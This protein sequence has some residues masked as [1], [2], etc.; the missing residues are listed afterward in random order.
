MRN[1]R[2]CANLQWRGKWKSD[3]EWESD[4]S[5]SPPKVTTTSTREHYD[6]NVEF[7]LYPTVSTALI[8]LIKPGLMK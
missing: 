2:K 4:P 6:S 1:A 8:H 7:Y 3:P 5:G